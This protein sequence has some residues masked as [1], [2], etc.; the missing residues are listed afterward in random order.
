MPGRIM[1]VDDASA[2]RQMISF[3]L[4]S[5]G[6]EVIEASDGK[7]ALRQLQGRAVDLVITD[8][9]M[10]NMN[11]IELTRQ[12][13]RQPLSQKTPI[14][15]LTTEAEPGKKMEGKS[16]GATG[17]I[18]KPFNQSQLVEIVKKVLG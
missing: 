4:K 1:T 7:D 5:A 17:W 11:G 14:L 16:A 8:I 18:V 13:R 2:M 12:L 3:T 9:N 15:I 6:Y 10:P